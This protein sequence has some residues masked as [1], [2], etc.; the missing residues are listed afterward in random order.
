MRGGARLF[1]QF[2]WLHTGLSNNIQQDSTTELFFLL[3]SQIKEG[4]MDGC[5]VPVMVYYDYFAMQ[6][7][8]KSV[9]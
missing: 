4:G 5:A 7:D 1:K 6:Q 2:W 9:V 8:R 3:I